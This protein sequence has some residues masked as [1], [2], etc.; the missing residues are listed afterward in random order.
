M[1]INGLPDYDRQ[2]KERRTG[3]VAGVAARDCEVKDTSNGKTFAAVSVRAYTKKD[4]T[5]VFL[6]IKSFDALIVNEMAPVRK[7]DRL[8]AA[9]RLDLREY[10]GKTYLDL[11]PDIFLVQSGRPAASAAARA[12][13]GTYE[14]ISSE[15]DIAGFAEVSDDGNL[16]F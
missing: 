16:P 12:S 4:G 1:Y 9:G 11:F 15:S 10:N 3:L 14:P 13:Y 7:G 6:Q 2:G 8:L 5:A